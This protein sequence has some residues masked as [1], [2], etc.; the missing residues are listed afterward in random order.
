MECNKYNVIAK[1][2]A[3]ELLEVFRQLFQAKG[4]TMQNRVRDVDSFY[5]TFP[6]CRRRDLFSMLSDLKEVWDGEKSYKEIGDEC[7]KGPKK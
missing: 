2:N 7:L 4:K 1:E 3:F 6:L 5:Q